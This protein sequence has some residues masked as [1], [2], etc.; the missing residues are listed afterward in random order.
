[1]PEPDFMANPERVG[2]ALQRQKDH[3]EAAE[4]R[5]IEQ[6]ALDEAY[7]TGSTP[8]QEEALREALAASDEEFG[9]PDSELTEEGAAPEPE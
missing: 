4:R 9:Q 5:R 7:P 3:E 6:E 8:Q 2:N 1:M